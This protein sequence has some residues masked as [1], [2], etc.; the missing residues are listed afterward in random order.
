MSPIKAIDADASRRRRRLST[1]VKQSLR[2]MSQQLALL[3][4]HVGAQLDLRAVD[5]QCLDLIVRFGPM[6]PS[7]L[8][9]RAGLHPATLT[10]VIDRLEGAGWIGRE[11]AVDDRR[12]VLLRVLRQRNSE[13]TGKYLG[14]NAFM[15][16]ICA[17]FDEEGLALIA[18]FLRRTEEA[19]RAATDQLGAGQ[20][21]ATAPAKDER[22]ADDAG[23]RLGLKRGQ[24]RGGID[25]VDL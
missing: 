23:P 17:D 3:N 20:S 24:R 18:I 4:H 25:G 14:M 1:E 21:V 16:E 10:G 22:L 2:A 19:G 8:A 11:R 7:A 15:D 5:L 9:K 13:L 12:S 6:G